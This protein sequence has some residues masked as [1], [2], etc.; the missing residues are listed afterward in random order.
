MVLLLA[1]IFNK[2][3]NI[4]RGEFYE[5]ALR[6]KRI[7]NIYINFFKFFQKKINFHSTN[8]LEKEII[9]NFFPKSF[10]NTIPN[11]ID[12][13]PPLNFKKIMKFYF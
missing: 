11:L 4:K 7:K 5:P 2:N 12:I 8:D 13:D 9:R 6:R 10:I 1:F 3:C